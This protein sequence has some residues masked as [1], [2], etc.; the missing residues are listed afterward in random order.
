MLYIVLNN[1]H[2]MS[3]TQKFIPYEQA[4]KL[5]EIGFDE[6]T[7]FYW[8]N[9]I[10]KPIPMKDEVCEFHINRHSYCSHNAP[11]PTKEFWISAPT[12][13]EAFEWF[14][15]KGYK[16]HILEDAWND[17]CT[18]NILPTNTIAAKFGNYLECGSFNSY[19]KAELACLIKLIEMEKLTTII[20]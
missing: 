18:P 4:L 2:N 15:K 8:E 1:T 14:R 20:K 7:S 3:K 6:A 19:K 11:I 13:Q 12:W 16:F 5:K 9:G 10:T 17:W